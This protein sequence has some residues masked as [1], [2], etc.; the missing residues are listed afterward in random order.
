[1]NVSWLVQLIQTPIVVYTI[2][3]TIAWTLIQLAS[4]LSHKEAKIRISERIL[5]AF[6]GAYVISALVVMLTDVRIFPLLHAIMLA[7]TL[8]A[9]LSMSSKRN[10]PVLWC[11]PSIHSRLVTMRVS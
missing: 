7:L 6:L 4:Q 5:L 1:M 10:A 2:V 3:L 8:W 11:R 9:I